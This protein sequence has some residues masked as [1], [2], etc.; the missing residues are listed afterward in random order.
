MPAMRNKKFH[1]QNINT[2][3]F[4]TEPKPNYFMHLIVWVLINK[5]YLSWFCHVLPCIWI[6]SHSIQWFQGTVNIPTNQNEKNL[7]LKHLSIYLKI[8]V[9]GFRW[10]STQSCNWKPTS[11]VI[12]FLKS[13]NVTQEIQIRNIINLNSIWICI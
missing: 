5:R 4:Q 6:L 12:R 7:F 3:V 2:F 8:W 13:L 1:R 11:H 10:V 9:D